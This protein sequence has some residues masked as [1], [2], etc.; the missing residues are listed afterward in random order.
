MTATT[1]AIS[2][3]SQVRCLIERWADAARRS[4]LD[5]VMNCY[6]PDVVAFD[7]ILALQ[8]KGAEAYRRHWEAC[9]AFAPPGEMIMEVHDLGIAAAGDVAFAHYV[10]R[11]GNRAADGKEQAGWMRATVCCRN[12]DD[13]WRIA[14]EHYSAP[15]DPESMQ[16]LTDLEP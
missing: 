16:M 7:A 15:F 14:H 9:L 8:V 2:T 3:E 11:C 5:T 6:T 4:D 10:S 1:T 13:G 12:T